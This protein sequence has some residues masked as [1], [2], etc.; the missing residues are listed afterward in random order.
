MKEILKLY[1]A[2]NKKQKQ[3]LFASGFAVLFVVSLIFSWSFKGDSVILDEEVAVIDK[4]QSKEVIK[5]LQKNNIPFEIEEQNG[6]Y[7]IITKPEYSNKARLKLAS[8][9]VNTSIKK[10]WNVFDKQSLGK[11]SFEN[12]VNL[13]RAMEG[14]MEKALDSIEKIKHSK[15]TIAIPKKSLFID[16]IEPPKVSV[17]LTLNNDSKM[18]SR[19]VL[20]IKKFISNSVPNLELKNISIIDQ[21]GFSLEEENEED[22]SLSKGN[23]Q[24]KYKKKI[25]I[26]LQKKIIEVI[27]PVVGGVDN[28]SAKVS[29]D[30]EFKRENY[31]SE[32]FDPNSVVRSE[33]NMELTENTIS[34]DKDIKGVP[35]AIS[36]IQKKPN[37]PSKI[38]NDVKNR[39]KTDVITNYE[40]SKTI[41]ESK[42]KSYGQVVK[43]GASVSFNTMPFKGKQIDKIKLK[44][45]NLVKSTINFDEKRGDKIAVEGFEFFTFVEQKTSND[46]LEDK[47]NFVDNI[48]SKYGFIVKFILVLI[49]LAIFYKLVISRMSEIKIV[50]SGN[51]EEDSED[52][53]NELIKLKEQKMRERANREANDKMKNEAEMKRIAQLK[54]EKKIRDELDGINSMSIEDETRFDVLLSNLHKNLTEKEDVVAKLI[55]NLIDKKDKK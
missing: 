19:Q 9:Q 48:I 13:I 36:N 12:R 46:I 50:E 52:D 6:K 54:L 39:E 27:S 5:E 28:I 33:K 30:M 31:T 45:E 21:T 55:E 1:E 38:K 53:E 4:S 47:L 25:E 24:F 2:L 34:N 17:V 20:G 42:N 18:N 37:I 51:H 16:K 44:I 43:I 40:I 32:T 11:S 14:E 35:G 41:S 10:G 7:V 3:V 22:V 15:V 23:E 29:I 8:I 26:D 49:I